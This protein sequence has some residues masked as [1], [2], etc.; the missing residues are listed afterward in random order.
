MPVHYHLWGGTQASGLV[1]NVPDDS[2]VQTVLRATDHPDNWI[3]C[4]G[5]THSVYTMHICITVKEEEHSEFSL[6]LKSH[7]F[8]IYMLYH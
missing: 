3:P 7:S 8:L 2:S 5:M 1:L 4:L 6:Y